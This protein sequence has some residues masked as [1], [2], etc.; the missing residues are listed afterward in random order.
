[1]YGPN[2]ITPKKRTGAPGLFLSQFKSPITLILIVAVLISVVL[3]ELAD[4]IIISFIIFLGG[5]L[6]FW[7]EHGAATAVE[8]LWAIV[9]VKTT[10]LR[11]GIE[12]KI[13]VEDVVPGDIVVL[14]A[15]ALV[16]GDCLLL[17]DKDMFVNEAS[18]TGESYPVDKEA[19]V[20]PADTPLAKRSNSLFMGTHVVSGQGRALV[21]RTGISTQFGLI[22]QRLGTRMPE[23][24]FERGVR[25][26]GY[27]L[28][29]IT[30]LLV[31]V[32]FA[33]NAY[34]AATN[35]MGQ[36]FIINALLFSLALAVGLTPQLLPA[37][38]SV[39]LSH[40]AKDMARKKVIVKRLMTIENFGSMNVLCSDKT[41]TLT[42]GQ[43]DVRA[44][45]DA[46]GKK[47]DKVLF[48]AA[49][50]SF[51]VS[52][53]PNIID[54]ALRKSCKQS[55]C[56]P[57]RKLDEVPYDFIRKR[58]SIL[59][60]KDG[61]PLMITKGALDNVLAACTT[62][63]T[64]NG[65][66]V[67][68]ETVRGRIMQDYLRL[69]NEGNRVLGVACLD[70]APGKKISKDSESK[71]TFIGFIVFFDP[72]KANIRNT[73]A[74]LDRLGVSLKMITGDNRLVAANVAGQVGMPDPH[75]LTGGELARMD[76]DALAAKINSINVFAEVE[77]NQKERII[78]ML[79]KSGNVVG[80]MGDG[81][82]DA[83]AIHAADV[84][85]SVHDAVDVAVDA[86]DIVLLE[87]DLGVL[88][89]GVKEGRVTFA[90]TMKYVFMATSANF[91]N[92]FS[93]AGASLFLTF[94]PLLP[95]QILL[96]NIMTDVPEMTIAGDSVDTELVARPERWNIH[97]IRNFMLVFGVL[98]SVFDY[99]T[100]AV[101][102]F[103]LGA[104]EAQFRT[105]WFLESVVSACLIVLVI[106]TRNIF[107]RSRPA[108]GLFL[109][110]MAIAVAV[111][112]L[113]F[114][115]LAGPFNFTPPS[116]IFLLVMLG[117]VAAYILS[118]EAVKRLF[119]K[120]SGG[121][122]ERAR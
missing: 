25:R 90:N 42:E 4:A 45:L 21:V 85:I 52:G 14:G 107:I 57:Y 79:K 55:D 74:E 75:V 59:V 98:S 31:I 38:I 58:L 117:L 84:G 30:L 10:V 119:Y 103:L 12:T 97:F 56:A 13:P 40:G 78:L 106:R 100:F 70:P 108:K 11:D 16:P 80:Y 7:Q 48:L 104:T 102:I 96:T 9:Q 64:S 116:P 19:A 101:L 112:I 17:E 47:S 37:I 50:N 8:K 69:S 94:L 62:A 3:G 61:S 33:I 1:M 27:L 51:Y 43:V 46:E 67:G 41:G 54:A 95:K 6:G 77:P 72:P 60:E 114:T 26:F 39:N 121:T 18:L 89:E 24:D 111:I 91:G 88:A 73:I 35:N 5:I 53:V 87:N 113:P 36:S 86:A 20:F 15:G 92:M 49:L 120:R 110:T 83:S 29:E 82:N 32:I 22:S 66:V 23:T 76:N 34:H 109:A 118:A 65:T 99:I 115:P 122:P 105:G 63:E 68:L 71:M 2:S 81:I 28:M 93:M 44:G